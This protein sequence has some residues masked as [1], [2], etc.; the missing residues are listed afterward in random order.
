MSKNIRLTLVCL[1]TV[2][3]TAG[4]FAMLRAPQGQPGNVE[5]CYQQGLKA[6]E[7]GRY[8][9]ALPHL[10]V[11]I[12]ES[13]KPTDK[14]GHRKMAT[15]LLKTSIVSYYF[16]DHKAA[17]S[18]NN[19]AMEHARLAG[20]RIQEA[21]AVC[22]QFAPL[23]RMG[24]LDEAERYNRRYYNM[25]VDSL[26]AF[27][28]LVNQGHL[29]YERGNI[30]NAER[31]F[32]ATIDTIAR[33]N[34]PQDMAVYPYSGLFA[35]YE[36]KGDI[37]KAEEYGQEYYRLIQKAPAE[38]RPTLLHDCYRGM[39]TSTQRPGTSTACRIT[40]TFISPCRTR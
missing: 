39:S 40:R 12:D 24:R 6:M 2:I 33:Y 26:T 7:Q 22:T 31:Y 15:A 29:E 37:A 20:D 11:Y 5:Q 10:L 14:E 28:Y 1:L 27:A 9:E 16:G 13:N 18:Y 8:L 36:G 17:I 34:F 25:H 23:F 32:K 19:M 21:K 4:G 30:E 38:K 35:I 3:T